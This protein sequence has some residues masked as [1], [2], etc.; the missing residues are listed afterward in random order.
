MTYRVLLVDDDRLD[1]ELL[2]AVVPWDELGLAVVGRA[3]S[4]REALEIAARN[5]I[6]IALL[7]VKLPG[8]DGLA[9]CASLKDRIPDLRVVFIS[10]HEQFEYARR[11]VELQADGYL[12]KPV[13]I[14]KLIECMRGIRCTIDR[15]KEQT[16]RR[17][18][19]GLARV[20]FLTGD[21]NPHDEDALG[22]P[23]PVVVAV[24]ADEE[25]GLPDALVM[26]TLQEHGFLH[27]VPVGPERVA[28]LV[29][30][31]DEAQANRRVDT[32][33]RDLAARG[34]PSA[35][36]GVGTLCASVR[37]LPASLATAEQRLNRALF[38][39]GAADSTAPSVESGI[40][41]QFKLALTELV[42]ALIQGDSPTADDTS[43]RL[44]EIA[45]AGRDDRVSRALVIHA[46]TEID[47]GL[48]MIDIDLFALTGGIAQ[49]SETLISASSFHE[50][51]ELLR[52][53]VASALAAVSEHRY[54]RSESLP[55][56][57]KNYIESRLSDDVSL[58][59]VAMHFAF[60]GNYLS[61]LLKR[62]TGESFRDI[63]SRLRMER[64]GH[65]LRSTK[66][67]VY[68]VA[69]RVGYHDVA[70]FSRLFRKHY[71]ISPGE[72]R[73]GE[74]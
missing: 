52:R 24:I 72:Y 51:S 54:T 12:V 40:V 30:A 37:E 55:T 66:M 35:T 58:D 27:F 7:D 68:E 71:G 14:R 4:A 36:A 18:E 65:L 2:E 29:P 28:V 39:T 31:H 74:A 56:E 11:A 8:T 60:S 15:D 22:V 6:E 13:D 59:D 1:L 49:L 48:S 50:L 67:F 9:L 26:E 47:N 61:H 43:A 41:R 21:H 69:D 57:V 16:I 62:E 20:L 42:H 46:I 73:Q 64:A 70:Y 23:M 38:F 32:L 45:E 5:E 19:W 34:R 33:R 25:S 10:A 63:L 17:N 53:V 44:L 3:H